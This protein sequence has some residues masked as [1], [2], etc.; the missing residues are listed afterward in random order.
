MNRTLSVN[1]TDK[2]IS[3]F[4]KKYERI[5]QEDPLFNKFLDSNKL[6]LSVLV[7]HEQECKLYDLVK[8][9]GSWV[10]RKDSMEVLVGG[11]SEITFSRVMEID[12]YFLKLKNE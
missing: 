4:G 11:T 1:L 5:N 6:R 12:E 9:N 3:T 7:E 10:A 2:I 8:E